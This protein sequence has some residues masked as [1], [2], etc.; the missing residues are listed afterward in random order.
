MSN[1]TRTRMLFDMPAPRYVSYSGE[2]TFGSQRGPRET[3]WSDF[4]TTD[5]SDCWLTLWYSADAEHM[6]DNCY[7]ASRW[8]AF[9][10]SVPIRWLFSNQH[11]EFFNI[12]ASNYSIQSRL[13]NSFRTSTRGFSR[14]FCFY[15]SSYNIIKTNRRSFLRFLGTYSYII[16]VWYGCRLNCIAN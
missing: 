1:C 15:L 16:M 14:S 6:N 4:L 5:C 8:V 11:S 12:Q 9:G 3:D 13:L 2:N 7:A 10:L